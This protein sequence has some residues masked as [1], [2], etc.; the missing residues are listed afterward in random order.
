MKVALE[1]NFPIDFIYHSKICTDFEGETGYVKYIWNEINKDRKKKIP[2]VIAYRLETA[3]EM[4]YKHALYPKKEKGRWC[5]VKKKLDPYTKFM[6]EF[7]LS[8]LKQD[9]KQ[10]IIQYLGIQ[11]QQIGPV[12]L[13]DLVLHPN[14]TETMVEEKHRNL[15]LNHLLYGL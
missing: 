4:Y 7:F 6:K 3:E 2:L 14:D 11:S 5:T 9:E 10:T 12:H 1:E 8:I 15:E 13:P